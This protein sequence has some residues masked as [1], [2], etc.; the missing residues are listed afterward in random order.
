MKIASIF[1]RYLTGA[2]LYGLWAEWI[3][4]FH[5][6]ARPPA[7]P[8]AIQNREEECGKMRLVDG[9]KKLNCSVGCCCFQ[10]RVPSGLRATRKSLD[11][12]EHT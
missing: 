9:D 7:N 2:D 8:F 12:T 3:S 6:P 1:A 5:P 10:L 11:G 4:Q